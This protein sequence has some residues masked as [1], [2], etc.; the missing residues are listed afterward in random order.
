MQ[1]QH[2]NSACI[3]AVSASLSEAVNGGA[4]KPL[5]RSARNMIWHPST[6]P[7]VD[8][9]IDMLL[10]AADVLDAAAAKVQEP[11]NGHIIAEGE[12]A[13]EPLPT[14]HEMAQQSQSTDEDYMEV[15]HDDK[16]AT[17]PEDPVCVEKVATHNVAKLECEEQLEEVEDVAQ[18]AVSALQASVHAVKPRPSQV[19]RSAAPVQVPANHVLPVMA[20]G[21]SK[22]V[23]RQKTAWSALESAHLRQ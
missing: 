6:K 18:Q 16:M 11:D 23:S 9:V 7:E 17:G 1:G 2:V 14:T 12:H 21:V 19:A 15:D 22:R 10:A 8:K 3:P 20:G 4:N 5:R 13:L